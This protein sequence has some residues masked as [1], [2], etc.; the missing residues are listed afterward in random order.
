[1]K[2]IGID[3]DKFPKSKFSSSTEDEIAANC[4]K[5]FL[6]KVDFTYIFENKDIAGIFR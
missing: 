3:I 2:A 5:E 1:M 6:D 4:V